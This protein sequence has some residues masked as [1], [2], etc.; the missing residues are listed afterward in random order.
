VQIFLKLEVHEP[1]VGLIALYE[2]NGA[3]PGHGGLSRECCYFG[4]IEK[5]LFGGEYEVSLPILQF[6]ESEYDDRCDVDDGDDDD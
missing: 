4:G 6:S 5:I 2:K 1:S 3:D